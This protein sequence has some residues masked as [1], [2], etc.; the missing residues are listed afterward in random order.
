MG[1][2]ATISPI[3]DCGFPNFVADIIP[4]ILSSGKRDRLPP[5]VP[6]FPPYLFT[7][8]SNEGPTTQYLHSKTQ[9]FNDG[10]NPMMERCLIEGCELTPFIRLFAP[11]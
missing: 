7:C 1:E 11:H 6:P 8:D 2:N 3:A 10:T 9:A 5:G 4:R